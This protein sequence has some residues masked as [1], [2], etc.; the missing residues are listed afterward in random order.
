MQVKELH[1]RG[2]SLMSVDGNGMT[3]LHHA[4][5]LGRLDVVEYLIKNGNDNALNVLHVFNCL[6]GQ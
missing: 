4:A 2:A 5:K 1:A 3:A 6:S